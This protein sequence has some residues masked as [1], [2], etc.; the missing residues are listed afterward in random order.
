MKLQETTH[1]FFDIDKD[2]SEFCSDFFCW[3][4]LWK[5]PIS[6]FPR[7]KP[8]CSQIH[9]EPGVILLHFLLHR[10]GMWTMRHSAVMS[11]RL[12]PSHSNAEHP[13][14]YHICRHI[15]HFFHYVY[16]AR[17]I[18]VLSSTCFSTPSFLVIPRYL[19][20]FFLVFLSSKIC[21]D[22]HWNVKKK[23]NFLKHK[24]WL[25]KEKLEWDCLHMDID[26]TPS[27][28]TQI[29]I[30]T[31]THLH[32]VHRNVFVVQRYWQRVLMDV[33]MVNLL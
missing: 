24:S 20:E 22:F 29:Y 8:N 19:L 7:R 13:C 31:H 11:F 17:S 16:D 4:Y 21:S 30:Q 15:S 6:S 33:E 3:E 1:S 2:K 25:V 14:K 23:T 32:T 28:C 10:E 26:I 9:F 5:A 18:A 12:L 27:R